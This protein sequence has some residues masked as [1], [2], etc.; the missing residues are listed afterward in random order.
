MA[1]KNKTCK[2]LHAPLAKHAK[3][4]DKMCVC[5]VSPLPS[6]AYHHPSQRLSVFG[7]PTSKPPAP[8]TVPSVQILI[9]NRGSCGQVAGVCVVCFVRV[10]L[11]DKKPKLGIEKVCTG[12]S[13][14]ANVIFV[15]FEKL[16]LCTW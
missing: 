6:L 5:Y 15:I 4:C 9:K 13:N 12:Q 3:T 2:H 11:K 16:K 8:P 7:T 1:S 10:V 14:Q